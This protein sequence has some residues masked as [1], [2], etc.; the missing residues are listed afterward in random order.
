MFFLKKSEFFSMKNTFGLLS[1]L[2]MKTI[3]GFVMSHLLELTSSVIIFLKCFGT[4]E[5]MCF[6]S[7]RNEPKTFPLRG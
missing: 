6:A 4:T 1:I 3:T 2:K 7:C 5:H